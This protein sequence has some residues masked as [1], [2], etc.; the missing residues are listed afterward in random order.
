MG[1]VQRISGILT[2]GPARRDRMDSVYNYVRIGADYFERVKIPGRLDSL[3]H[4][5]KYCTV[6]VAT[7]R[8][9]SPFFYRARINVVYAVEV[10]GMVHRAI[11]EVKRGWTSAKWLMV[12]VLLGVGAA[13]IL[14]YIG[15]LF[16]IQ[17]VRLSFVEMPW[18]E[19][20]SNPN[21]SPGQYM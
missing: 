20:R 7:I 21:L 11:D 15:V 1:E 17:A 3:L 14:L 2:L 16:W 10:D 9:P 12:F 13:T 5:G 6:W 4:S 18:K 19:M 8:T